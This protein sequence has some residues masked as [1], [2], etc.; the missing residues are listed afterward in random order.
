MSSVLQLQVYNTDFHRSTE[1]NIIFEIPVFICEIA[2]R[3]LTCV[4]FATVSNRV[5]DSETH[6]T[7]SCGMECICTSIRK[8]S[9]TVR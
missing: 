9:H 6:L 3:R 1:T 5:L 7:G 8:I 4:S 2:R